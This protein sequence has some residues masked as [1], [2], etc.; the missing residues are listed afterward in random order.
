M[1]T[2]ERYEDALAK[3]EEIVARM[4]QGD[5]PLEEML[6]SFE[7]GIRLTRICA[8]KLDEAE[9]RVQ[10]LLE[11]EGTIHLQTLREEEIE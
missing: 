6:K 3:L 11:E 2:K 1:P 8:K 4:S 9:R 10:I 7:E 5:L